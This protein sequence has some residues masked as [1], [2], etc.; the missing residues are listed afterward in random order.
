MRI[1]VVG[2]GEKPA[3]ARHYSS[4]SVVAAFCLFMALSAVLGGVAV[5]LAVDP[6]RNVS[7]EAVADW[8]RELN[9]QNEKIEELQAVSSRDFDALA[10]RLAQ[11]QG[12]LTR[13]DALGERLTEMAS[14]DKGEFDFS[15]QPAQGGPEDGSLLMSDIERPDFMESLDQ[16]ARDIEQRHQQLQIL[17]L[18]LS[19]R[20]LEDEQSLAGWPVAKGWLSSRFGKRT[21][22][23]TGKHTWHMGLDFAGKEGTDV[24]AIAAGVVTFSGVRGGFGNLVEISHAGGYI[25]RYAHNKEN[26]VKV[27]DAI[28]KGQ[29]VAKLGNTG[30]STGPHVHLEVLLN[31]KAVDPM[32]FIR[33]NQ[34]KG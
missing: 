11:L 6:G 9:I 10:L 14:L 32:R 25:T 33:R 21:D 5:W 17:E 16:L 22:P 28:N 15:G 34:K 23:F 7:T 20:Q 19:N 13:I 1:I 18:F 8:K 29:T 3:H 27:G 12:R 4:G 30:R 2:R 26:T 24:L 31:N